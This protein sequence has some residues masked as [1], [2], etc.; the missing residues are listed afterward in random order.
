MIG[1]LY[2]IVPQQTA[3]ERVK[4]MLLNHRGSDDPITSREINEEISEDTVGSFPNTRSIIRDIMVE[5]EIPIAGSSQGYYVIETEEELSE[6]VD[7]LD[8]RV[9]N[10][11]ERKTYV[12]RAAN[13]WEDQIETSDDEDLL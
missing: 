7:N 5:D 8:Q 6:Y 13:E 11:T 9:L 1:T 2:A 4:E 12:L 3:R 10:I